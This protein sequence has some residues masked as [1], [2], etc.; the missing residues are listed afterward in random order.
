L[1]RELLEEGDVAMLAQ[2]QKVA[3]FIIEAAASIVW[4][5]TPEMAEATVSA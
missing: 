4:T 1:C 2:P 3:D 5:Q